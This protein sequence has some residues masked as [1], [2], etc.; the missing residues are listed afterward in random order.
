MEF[1]LS[2]DIELADVQQTASALKE[3][4]TWYKANYPYTI[5][6]ISKMEEALEVLNDLEND[7][8]N[9]E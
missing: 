7:V 8:A 5:Y 2:T 1:I 3:K 4:I 9:L 6:E